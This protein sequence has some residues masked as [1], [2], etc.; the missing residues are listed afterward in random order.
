MAGP[1]LTAGRIARD[2]SAP[3][4]RRAPRAVEGVPLTV[5]T[6]DPPRLV[7]AADGALVR[8][9]YPLIDAPVT[10]TVPRVRWLEE[11]RG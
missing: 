4:R 9:R 11:R 5:R 2:R 1:G 6:F 8:V 7:R 10:G 3:G